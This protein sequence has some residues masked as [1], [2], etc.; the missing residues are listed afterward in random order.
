MGWAL[1][2]FGVGGSDAFVQIVLPRLPLVTLVDP[3][4][5][6]F[7]MRNDIK[8]F[9]IFKSCSVFLGKTGRDNLILLFLLGA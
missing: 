1:L 5:G 3:F 6:I 4:Q 9:Q 2:A 8:D 7:Q